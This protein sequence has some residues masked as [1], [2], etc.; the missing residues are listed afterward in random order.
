MP[1]QA[2]R[3]HAARND[4]QNPQP[5]RQ[6]TA[7]IPR[8]T[9]MMMLLLVRV[10]VSTAETLLQPQEAEQSNHRKGRKPIEHIHKLDKV[11][12]FCHKL[13]M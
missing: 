1:D 4:E 7:K 3:R 6:L 13:T 10:A 5:D 12:A 11:V 9:M 8:I 2:K